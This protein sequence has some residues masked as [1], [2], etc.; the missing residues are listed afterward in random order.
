M[1]TILDFIRKFPVISYFVLTFAVSWGGII[2][3]MV[4]MGG[5]PTTKEALNAQLP[6][7]ILLMIVGPC[8]SGLLMTGLVDG[9]PGFRELFSRL[10]KWRVG[11]RWYVIALL[12]A[13]LV[14]LAVL[15]ALLLVSPVYAPGIFEVEKPIS[16]LLFV[17]SAALVTGILE[18]IGWVG[19]AVPRLRNRYSILS[20]G[21]IVG[22]LW[23]GWHIMGQVVMASGSYSGEIS[24][25]FF[26]VAQTIGLLIGILPAFRI[27]MVWVYDRTGSLL[28]AIIMHTVLTGAT[29]LLEPIRISGIPL[30]TYGWISAALMWVIALAVIARNR[31]RVKK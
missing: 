6:V 28:I 8:F 27:L 24:L 7:A 31:T 13:P 17:M 21:L 25:H 15:L 3:V 30:F 14:L 22:I 9:K 16:R 5:I 20:T 11:L 29:M 10:R 18:E 12:T 1:K 4:S 23:G 26:L 2:L 19:F